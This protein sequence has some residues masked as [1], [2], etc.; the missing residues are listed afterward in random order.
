[1]HAYFGRRKLFFQV[2]ICES[3][4][5]DWLIDQLI[6]WLTDWHRFCS[7]GWPQTP[8]VAPPTM[9][10]LGSTGNWTLNFLQAGQALCQLSYL[11]SPDK[12]LLKHFFGCEIIYYTFI[13]MH[14]SCK[15]QSLAQRD[16]TCFDYKFCF[17][18]VQLDS[19]NQVHHESSFPRSCYTTKS[20]LLF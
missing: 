7:P 16:R 11:P 14:L 3:S 1:M 19:R 2:A 17:A 5:T 20:Y 8:F 13:P 12:E 10:I 18:W 9:P 4:L 15:T 6:D